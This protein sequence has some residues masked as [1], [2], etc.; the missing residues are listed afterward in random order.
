ML[1]HTRWASVGIISQPN[2]HPVD[3]A[4]VGTGADGFDAP[5]V[6]AS[7]NGDVDNFADLKALD[8]LA[9]APEITTDAKV[10]PTLVARR[11]AEG[12]DLVHGLPQHGGQLR[13]VGRHRRLRQRRSRQAAARPAGQ[14]PGAVRRPGRR[15]LHRRQRALRRHRA[16]QPTTCAWT[17][18]RPPT[19][20]TRPPAAVRSWCSTAPAAGTLEGI[21]RMAYDGTPLPVTDGRRR[22]WPRSP[23]ATSTGATSRTSCSRRSPRP[24]ASFRKTLRGKLVERDGGVAVVLGPETLPDDVRAALRSGRHRPGARHRPGHRGRGRPVA[25]RRAGPLLRRD[26]P[27]GSTPCRPPSCPAS[28]CGR[29]WPTRSSSRSASRAPPPTPTARS[30]SC[31]PGAP[32]SSPSSTAGAAT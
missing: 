7:L 31:A 6:V 3:S 28:G 22:R 9:I 27:C 4:E 24:P 26:R 29:R 1:G 8:G 32:G 17:A 2:A 10:I 5:Y 21:E 18:R 19:P 30:T 16:D 20:T 13:G 25:G 14:R 11:V 15:G 23:P 12:A